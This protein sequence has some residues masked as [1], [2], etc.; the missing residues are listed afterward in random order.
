ME[1]T[2]KLYA[3]LGEYLPPDAE[4]NVAKLSVPDGATV[5]EAITQLNLPT[6]YTHLVLVNGEYIEP[7][8]RTALK[9]KPSDA[10]A[11]WPPIAGG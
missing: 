1:I 5:E 8:R 9:L 4:R 7:S 10:L 6:R 2:I 11:V 3:S